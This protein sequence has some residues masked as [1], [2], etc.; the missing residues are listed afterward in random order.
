MSARVNG[1]ITWHMKKVLNKSSLSKK[2]ALLKI[3]VVQFHYSSILSP[4]KTT[5]LANI[6]VHVIK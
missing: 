1:N 3:R 2:P 5:L 4:A 6:Q